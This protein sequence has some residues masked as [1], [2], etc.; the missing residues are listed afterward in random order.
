MKHIL[1]VFILLGSFCGQVFAA[2]VARPNII[3]ILADD[4][5]FESLGCY[6]GASYKGIGPV[7]TPNFDAMAKN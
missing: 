5:G 3:F 4:L 7:H 1:T 2:A 6:G